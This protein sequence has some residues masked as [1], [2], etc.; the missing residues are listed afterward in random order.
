MQGAPTLQLRCDLLW[1]VSGTELRIVVKYLIESKVTEVK[2]CTEFGL[3]CVRY[4]K[5]EWIR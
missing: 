4:E 5:G 2:W 1:L 3:D